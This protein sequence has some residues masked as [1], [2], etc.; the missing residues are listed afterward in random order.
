MLALM[1]HQHGSHTHTRMRSDRKHWR[2]W[3]AINPCFL[4]I[5]R[6]AK[7]KYM[8]QVN[9]PV[10]YCA[11]YFYSARSQRSV[12]QRRQTTAGNGFNQLAGPPRFHKY[13]FVFKAVGYWQACGAIVLD[14]HFRSLHG[15]RAS[16]IHTNEIFLLWRGDE[17]TSIFSEGKKKAVSEE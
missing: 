10:I 8:P 3:S 5:C 9:S 4:G 2:R 13:G 6:D 11:G 16:N 7:N 1:K 15:L 17:Q 12:T 14:Y